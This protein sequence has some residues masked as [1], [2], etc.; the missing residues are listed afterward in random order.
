MTVEIRDK[1]TDS[2]A[3]RT[4]LFR[5]IPI[6]TLVSYYFP[7]SIHAAFYLL[8]SSEFLCS[9]MCDSTDGSC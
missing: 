7:N 2:L 9:N 3:S 1:Q 4:P 6:V 5:P 8:Y